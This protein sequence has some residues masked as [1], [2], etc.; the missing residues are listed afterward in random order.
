M[1]E[2]QIVP[3][4]LIFDALTADSIQLI[5]SNPASICIWKIEKSQPFS[6]QIKIQESPQAAIQLY[7]EYKR[8]YAKRMSKKVDHETIGDASFLTMSG[9]NDPSNE[10]TLLTLTQDRVV[11]I[12]YYPHN[13]TELN[14]TTSLAI[15]K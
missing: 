10:A 13:P 8:A 15:S 6:I 11:A 7:N 14:A 2:C 5:E 4:E 12:R 9:P 1:E 3:T